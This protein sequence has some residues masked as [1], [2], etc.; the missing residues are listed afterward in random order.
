MP[1]GYLTYASG[2]VLAAIASGHRYG[3]EIMDITGLPSGTVYPVLR[4]FERLAYVDSL[5]EDEDEA[6]AAGRPARRYYEVTAAGREAIQAG[7]E[8]FPGI[9]RAV[10]APVR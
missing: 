8:R 7:G 6:H 3:F 2:I 4:K 1:G 5:W 10:A 9:W